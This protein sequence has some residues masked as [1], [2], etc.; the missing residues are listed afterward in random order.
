MEFNL[1]N[2][3]IAQSDRTILL[4]ATH[5]L[6]EEAR[7]AISPFTELIKSPEYIHTYRITPLSLWNAAAAG[8]NAE[9]ICAILQ[10]YAKYGAP[11][12][13]LSAIRDYTARYGLLRIEQ[14]GDK[15]FLTCKDR[16]LLTEVLQYRDLRSFFGEER[17][18]HQVEV[19][20]FARGV[21]KQELIRLGYP[22]QDIAG[23][24]EGTRLP[25]ALKAELRDYQEQAVESY[26]VGGSVFGGNGVL[27]LPCGA[28]KTVIGIAAM[29]K[30]GMETLVLTT[31]VTSVR[32]WIRE[33]LDKTDLSEEQVG[34][35]SSDYK[36]VKPIT[37]T[38]Y[39]MLTHRASK[40]KGFAHMELFNER[41]WGFIVYDEVHTLPAPIFRL[42][43]DI[44]AKRRLGL[45][46][47]LVREDGREEDVFTLVGPK[48]FDMPWKELEQQGWLAT[49]SCAEIRIRLP[50]ALREKYV[51]AESRRKNRIAAEN[52]LKETVVKQ[53][54]ERH[55]DEQVLIIGQYVDQLEQL[56]EAT[57][58]PV[59][60]G[61]TPHTERE[62]LYQQF[63]ERRFSC[64]I[65]S[66][67]A[68]F[69]V[70]LPDASVA[71]QVSGAFGSR[72]EE[73]QRL[74]RVLRPKQGNNRSYFYTIV[75]KGTKEEDWAQKR[76]LFLI[77]QGYNYEIDEPTM[78]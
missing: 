67:V 39:Q 54:L 45:T 15:L 37:V 22:T 10:Q 44:Q 26:Y 17:T 74:G 33:I 75:S 58:A 36:Q 47:T 13:L 27:V 8:L 32:Q 73:A 28:G 25:I 72:Q 53:L 69:A 19:M 78:D 14:R 42:A 1:N 77:E 62:R 6:F 59:I 60:T 55:A 63:R 34:E 40:D 23:Y 71:I 9:Q 65:V 48:R 57:G 31:N 21:I 70:D 51:Y 50:F 43:A 38:T 29:A 11:E 61:K 49:A 4:E 24:V 30:I 18:E 68:N 3:L 35:Y 46:A 66:K 20:P 76:Q 16:L 41:N 12:A 64:L 7:N 2:P 5:P 52:P 56:G